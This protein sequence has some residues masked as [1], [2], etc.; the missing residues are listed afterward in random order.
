MT[1]MDEIAKCMAAGMNASQI[2]IRVKRPLRQVLNAMNVVRDP[3]REAKRQAARYA[4]ERNDPAVMERKRISARKASARKRGAK[5]NEHG[6]V[7]RQ[8]A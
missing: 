8:Q 2:A 7:I 5:T 6:Y 4:R 3:D 1:L